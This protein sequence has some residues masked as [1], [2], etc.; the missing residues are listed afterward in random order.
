[1]LL[2]SSYTRVKKC[3]HLI[4]TS[5]STDQRKTIAT[6][7]PKAKKNF[8]FQN[9][10]MSQN[11]D[12]LNLETLTKTINEP[13]VDKIASDLAKIKNTP[14]FLGK[15]RMMLRYMHTF[16]ETKEAAGIFQNLILQMIHSETKSTNVKVKTTADVLCLSPR[17][18]R[19]KIKDNKDLISSKHSDAYSAIEKEERTLKEALYIVQMLKSE[20]IAETATIF[21]EPAAKAAENCHKI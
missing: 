18:I 19:S 15:T 3:L 6:N 20:M 2:T 5:N 12:A 4:A 14:R 16:E 13:H 1:M 8:A 17:K 9:L 11:T 7:K 10:K 21:Q